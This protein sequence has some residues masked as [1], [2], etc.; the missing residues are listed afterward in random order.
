M[1]LRCA[2]PLFQCLGNMLKLQQREDP[3]NRTRIYNNDRS[4]LQFRDM[5]G[6][7]RKLMKGTTCVLEDQGRTPEGRDIRLKPGKLAS[8]M[9]GKRVL[10]R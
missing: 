1:N 6:S 5:W 7:L 9:E 10:G 2:L 3:G 4:L 8:E